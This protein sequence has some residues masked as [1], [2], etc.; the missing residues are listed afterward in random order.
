MTFD[1]ANHV[2]VQYLVWNTQTYFRQMWSS[3]WGWSSVL[4]L[5]TIT[6]VW[7]SKLVS[8]LNSRWFPP[9]HSIKVITDE[10]V[11][12]GLPSAVY[13]QLECGWIVMSPQHQTLLVRYLYRSNYYLYF[14]S[15]PRRRRGGNWPHKA[16]LP[17][18]Y[19]SAVC[20][21]M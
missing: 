6:C 9:N 5:A 7:Q 19:L 20:L 2:S 17:E 12:N 21:C 11:L 15:T 1:K 10:S 13:C 4:L 18:Q 14:R 3:W 8:S 16:I